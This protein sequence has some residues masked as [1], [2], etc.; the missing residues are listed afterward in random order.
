MQRLEQRCDAA[1]RY[2]AWL[3]HFVQD[4]PDCVRNSFDQPHLVQ[5]PLALNTCPSAS[6][7]AGSLG[8]LSASAGVAT[9]VDS[10]N[11]TTSSWPASL[12]ISRAVLPPP[13]MRMLRS[14]PRASNRRTIS[15][16]PL[17]LAQ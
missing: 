15:M 17:R 10:S 1:V 13:F 16:C 2:T 11:R 12:A 8:M 14:A 3:L 5:N 9:S 7:G 6:L 4:L